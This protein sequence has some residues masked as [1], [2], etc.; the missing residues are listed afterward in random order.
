MNAETRC[1]HCNGLMPANS[2]ICFL[3]G[4]TQSWAESIPD[5][6]LAKARKHLIENPPTGPKFENKILWSIG[7]VAFAI[8][9]LPFTLPVVYLLAI[10]API[11][12]LLPLGLFGLTIFWFLWEI[13]KPQK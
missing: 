6:D 11:S 13:W 5:E 12:A 1:P 10:L 3:C 9:T 7:I 8:I 2:R 4:K